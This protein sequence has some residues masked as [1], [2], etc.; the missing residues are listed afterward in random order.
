MADNAIGLIETKGYV[1]ALAAPRT[2]NW[3]GTSRSAVT[4]AAEQILFSDVSRT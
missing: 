3:P 4:N 1:A 2:P